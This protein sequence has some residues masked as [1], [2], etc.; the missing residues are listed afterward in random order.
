MG[1]AP[2]GG[3]QKSSTTNHLLRCPC[4]RYLRTEFSP[5]LTDGLTDW[6][7]GTRAQHQLF[8]V[9]RRTHRRPG[10]GPGLE[11]ST[12]CS[13]L[14]TDS[15]SGK[16]TSWHPNTCSGNH[17]SLWKCT[18]TVS[19]WRTPPSSGMWFGGA[20]LSPTGTAARRLWWDPGLLS[21]SGKLNQTLWICF[22]LHKV[23]K[24]MPFLY[25]PG[26]YRYPL[27][28]AA[29]ALWV[30]AP[31]MQNRTPD[32]WGRTSVELLNSQMIH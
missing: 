5:R 21:D 24:P 1:L 2:S 4:C 16:G 19:P 22:L 32:L 17:V 26:R 11:A 30:R 14:T 6:G 20:L 18:T 15:H 3:Q 28:S 13:E 25:L 7:R 8:P 23:T 29:K 10:R 27:S 12:L 9:P 31:P